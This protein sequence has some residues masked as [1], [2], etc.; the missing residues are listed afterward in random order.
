MDR[1][2]REIR[3]RIKDLGVTLSNEEEKSLETKITFSVDIEDKII[4]QVKK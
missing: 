4:K 3:K 1:E 2:V